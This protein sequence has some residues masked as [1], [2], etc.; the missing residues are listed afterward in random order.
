MEKLLNYFKW[1]KWEDVGVEY[2]QQECKY[3]LI[4]TRTRVRNNYRQIRHVQI[5]RFGGGLSKAVEEG[6]IEILKRNLES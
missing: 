5:M 2:I 3:V 4:Q 6:F 1:N